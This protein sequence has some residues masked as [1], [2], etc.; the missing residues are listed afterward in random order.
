MEN[1][2]SHLPTIAETNLTRLAPEVRELLAP[3]RQ[4]PLAVRIERLRYWCAGLTSLLIAAMFTT[5]YMPDWCKWLLIVSDVVV[6]LR[7]QML[8]NTE[9]ALKR[10][11]HE[12]QQSKNPK[13]SADLLRLIL[14]EQ[15]PENNELIAQS[16]HRLATD[17]LDNQ[18]YAEAAALYQR[19]RELRP[20]GAQAVQ[21][22][23]G[24]ARALRAQGKHPE[25][26][27]LLQRAIIE[28]GTLDI[29]FQ[30]VKGDCLRELALHYWER[31]QHRQ[32][33]QLFSEA[34]DCYRYTD[35]PSP[36]LECNYYLWSC[37]K[38]ANDS[39]AC[40]KSFDIYSYCA[41][42]RFEKFFNDPWL[43]K[44][45]VLLLEHLVRTGA[46]SQAVDRIKTIAK[47]LLQHLRNWNGTNAEA[48]ITAQQLLAALIGKYIDLAQCN[49]TD[50][51][52]LSV[53]D[54]CEY[55]EALGIPCTELKDT[56]DRIHAP[57]GTSTQSK[58]S[59]GVT[60]DYHA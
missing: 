4:A 10:K 59:K 55:R 33:R 36:L 40:T 42:Y 22:A 52:L 18:E 34:L 32:A 25:V 14:D 53:I 23:L 1:Q 29:R 5:H 44:C 2:E 8:T 38:V 27:P 31:G 37:L 9:F 19:Q 21:G 28:A 47:Q 13:E 15:A 49:A 35:G 11:R 50:P 3:P 30:T 54:A 17:R 43:T 12:L 41:L 48:D 20:S 39:E 51:T 6:M 45:E 26:V 57:T 7:L 58:E 60:D 16:Y 56:C 24:L 46:K